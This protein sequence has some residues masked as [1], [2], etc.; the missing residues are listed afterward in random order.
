MDAN[1]VGTHI[2]KLQGA[3]GQRPES[4]EFNDRDAFEWSHFSP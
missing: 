2:G 4:G 3:V 1:D